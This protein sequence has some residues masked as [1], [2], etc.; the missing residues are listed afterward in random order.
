[1]RI[2]IIFGALLVSACASTPNVTGNAKGG[3]MPWFATNLKAAHGAADGHCRKYGKQ[4]RIT[5]VQA[6]AG[7]SVVFDCV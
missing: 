2:A 6:E 1:M 5:S 4:A 3:V 7:G